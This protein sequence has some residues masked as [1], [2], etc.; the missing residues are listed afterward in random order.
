[1]GNP[2]DA[3]TALRVMTLLSGVA[4]RGTTVLCSLHQPRPRVFNLLDR[5]ILLSGGR[6]AYTGRPGDAEAFFRSVGRPFPRHQPHPA[7]AMLTLVCREDGRDLPSLFRRSRL[8]EGAPREAAGGRAVA[9]EAAEEERGKPKGGGDVSISGS[10]NGDGELEEETELVEVG[11]GGTRNGE[12]E[13][14]WRASRR[15]Q[16]QRQRQQ[17]L[18]P[19]ENKKGAGDETSSAPF[20]VQ[21]EALSRRL[22]LRAVRHPLLLVL[23]LGGSV[24]MAL[25]LASVF[26]GRLGYNLAGAQDRRVVSSEF[27]ILFFLL[28]YLALLSLTSLPVWREDRRLFLSEAMGGAYGHLPYFTS[29]A[30]ADILLIRVLPPLAFAVVG[31]PLMGL[32]SEPDNP[33]C[34]LWFAG[35]LVLANVTVALAAMGIGA[36]GLPLDLSNLIGGL[37]VLLLAAFGRFLLNGTRIPVAWRWLNSVTPLGYAFEALLINE[38]SD[39]D[40]RRPYRIEGSHCSP[41]LPVIM[42]LGPQILATF[43]FSTERSTMHKDMLV[44]VSLAVGLSVSSLLVFFLATRTKPLVIGSYPTSGQ[45]RPS[46]RGNTR[47][48]NNSSTAARYS[49]PVPSPDH[50]LTAADPP[51]DGMQPQ[52]QEQMTVSTA[53][54]MVGEEQLAL[55]SGQSEGSADA[56]GA[57]RGGA[58]TVSWNVPEALGGPPPPGAAAASGSRRFLSQGGWGDSFRRKRRSSSDRINARTGAELE[59]ATPPPPPLLLSWEGLRYEIAVPRRRGSWFGKGDAAT[60]AAPPPPPPPRAGGGGA[61]RGEV[62]RLLVLDSVSGFAGPTRSAG[63]RRAG[64]HG[65]E[66]GGWGGT[67]TAIMGPSGAGKTSLLNALAGRL[68]D[69]QQEASGGGRR[70]RP[71]LTGAVRLNGLAASPAEVRALSAYVTQEDVLPETLTC[72]EHLMFHAQLRLPGHTTL[73]RRHD[74]VVEVLEQLGLEDIRDSRIGGGLSRGISGGE[75]RRL[76][77]GTELLTRPALLFLDEPT[78]GLDSSTA[79]RVM[80]LVSEIASLGTTVVCSVHQPRPEVVRLI[81]K[82]ILLSRGAVAFCGAPS[83]AEAHFATIG[84]PFSR[85]GAG[86]TSGAS[87]G[88]GGAGGAVAGGINPADAILDVIGEAEDRVDREGV[89]GGVESGVGLVVMPRQQLVEQVRAAETSGPPPTS[90]FGIHGSATIGRTPPPVCTQLSALLQ[91]ASINVARDPYLAGLHIVLTVFVGVVVGSLFRDLGRLNGCTAGVR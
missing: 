16:R 65:N 72:Y 90:L 17:Q 70:R 75:K 24:A 30:L 10:L 6:V 43:S 29:V 49:N 47:T 61:R 21:V 27:G 55:E 12:R 9:A 15:R 58:R 42:P 56:G 80:K 87:G 86:A 22:L 37:M 68:Q 45:T 59:T 1:P 51:A 69:V 52:P 48:G 60:T 77:I 66:G 76:S 44:L 78:T 3:A 57:T 50:G 84:R 67:V 35:I 53:A 33:G 26:E 89:G 91:R 74:R 79:V 7:D 2:T 23:H 73:A 20:L 4:S 5:V 88:A 18:A 28:L 83:D 63:G 64:G 14:R 32:N 71:G 62:E 19:E 31:Y 25:C 36:L 11:R 54:G 81:H 39:A 40:G 82:V 13:G 85:P 41:D 8:S 38:F 34:L 46:R